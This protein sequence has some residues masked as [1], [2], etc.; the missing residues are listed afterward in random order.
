MTQMNHEK[1]IKE[2]QLLEQLLRETLTEYFPEEIFENYVLDYEQL[3]YAESDVENYFFEHM[4]KLYDR[5]F[6]IAMWL[7]A[8]LSYLLGVK[9][10]NALEGIKAY[11]LIQKIHVYLSWHHGKYETMNKQQA[12]FEKIQAKG[13]NA[14]AE[15]YA[16]RKTKV[17]E[18]LLKYSATH[19]WRSAR[20]AA[21][22]ILDEVLE[23]DNELFEQKKLTG[24]TSI[25][26]VESHAQITISRWINEDPQ[27]KA[28][29]N[30]TKK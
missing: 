7:A 16:Q 23:Y 4:G 1:L 29:I 14:R 27:L 20:K 25:R 9:H 24:K 2:Y 18:L 19:S 22:F 26:L 6:T 8:L 30:K 15:R 21:L 11:D 12:E 28:L 10:L 17:K 5:N 13:R 3:D